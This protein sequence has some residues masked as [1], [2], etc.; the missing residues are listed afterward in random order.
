[1]VL[2]TRNENFG[3]TVAEA[4]AAETPVVST[5]GAPWAGMQAN[6]CGWWIDFGA[7]PLAATLRSALAVPADELSAMGRRGRAWMARDFGWTRVAADMA[8]L[9]AWLLHGGEP[10]PTVRLA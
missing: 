7:E 6:R 9:Y 3:M 5:R 1:V 8:E 2:P 10:P 4:L